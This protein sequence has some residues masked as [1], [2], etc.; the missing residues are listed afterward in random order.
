MA[1]D[2]R[3]FLKQVGTGAAAVAALSKLVEQPSQGAT[4]YRG[5]TAGKFSLQLDGAHVGWIQSFEGGQATADVVTEKVNDGTVAHKHL[6]GVK[7][8]DITI[9]CG[10]GMSKAFYEWIKASF[11]H[12]HERKDGAIVAADYNFNTM[13]ILSFSQAL[14]SEIGFPACDAGSKDAAKMTL[15]FSPAL[16]QYQFNVGRPVF[17]EPPPEPDKQTRWLVSNF[18]LKIDGLDEASARVNKIEAITVKQT[19]VEDSVGEDRG[20]IPGPLDYS[21]LKITL[22]EHNAG[23]VTAWHEDF[24]I[25]GE[26]GQDKERTGTLEFLTEDLKTTL[27][28][29]EFDHLGIFKLT[30]D[31]YTSDNS[32]KLRHIQA[33]MYVEEIKFNPPG[34]INPGTN[35]GT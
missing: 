7:Y 19:V 13:T 34:S 1:N 6:A 29:L 16:T 10:A 9:S 3:D 5:F 23:E 28:S 27:F 20:L 14:I 35:P 17:Q 15:K 24:V 26:N 32:G 18:R 31:P 21:D 2:R 11:D 30:P 25:K 22:P 4:S 33:E 8:E 12:K